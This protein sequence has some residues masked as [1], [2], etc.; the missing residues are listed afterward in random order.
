[1]EGIIVRNF[2]LCFA[3]SLRLR[4][5]RTEKIMQVLGWLSNQQTPPRIET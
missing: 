4:A 5:A 2:D 3:L 1:V